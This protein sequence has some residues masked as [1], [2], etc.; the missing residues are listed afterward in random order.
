MMWT[1]CFLISSCFLLFGMSPSFATATWEAANE[2]YQQGKYEEAKVDY[3]QLVEKRE[4]SADLFYNLGNAWFKLGDPGRAILNY[5]RALVLNPR[6][7]EASSN[8]RTALKIVGNDDQPTFREQIGVYADYFPLAASIAFWTAG[9]CFIPASRK[10]GRFA[11][12]WRT[13]L[14]AAMLIFVGSVGL[15]FWV[16]SGSKDP[17]RALVV[18]SATD[19]KYGPAVTARPVESLQIGQQVQLISE[20]GAWTFCRAS[21]DSLGWIPT[22]KAERVIP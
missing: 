18:E 20:R 21:T 14:I 4:Y 11:T 9:C 2:A 19:L 8:L 15:S 1:K 7:E 22:R 3:I 16:G 17:N 5:E 6:L 10:H 12:F 13:A